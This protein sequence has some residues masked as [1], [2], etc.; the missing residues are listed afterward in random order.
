MQPP[1]HGLLPAKS[2]VYLG[3]AAY[4]LLGS[5]HLR[6]SPLSC[7]ILPLPKWRNGRRRGLKIPRSLTVRVRVPFSAPKSTC[8]RRGKCLLFVL[9]RGMSGRSMRR[10]SG[11]PGAFMRPE[12]ESGGP[13]AVDAVMHRRCVTQPAR[14]AVDASGC[15]NPASSARRG[16]RGWD[17][18]QSG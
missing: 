4:H 5:A 18:T 10:Y 16:V 9:E 1:A 7:I 6:N 15:C 11:C 14:P 3:T 8:L 13:Y 2:P 17:R 12:K